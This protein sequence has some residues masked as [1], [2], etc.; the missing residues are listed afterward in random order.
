M[1]DGGQVKPHLQTQL[2][3]NTVLAQNSQPT[4]QQANERS[5]PVGLL[6]GWPS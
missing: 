1:S 3:K 2:K 6:E 5:Q 4:N